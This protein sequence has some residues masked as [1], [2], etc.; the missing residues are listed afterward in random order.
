MKSQRFPWPSLKL[1]PAL[2]G[3]LLVLAGTLTGSVVVLLPLAAWTLAAAALALLLLLA[4]SYVRIGAAVLAV[5]GSRML[6]A[7]GNFPELL[8]F[9]HFP[10]V[11]LA[12][13]VAATEGAPLSSSRQALGYGLIALLA[14]CLL[15]W[16][17]NGGQPIRPLLDWLVFAEPFLLIY[18]LAAMP[19]DPRKMKALWGL[20]LALPFAQLPLAGYQALSQGISDPVQGLFLGM[21]AGAHVAGG[22]TLVGSLICLAKAAASAK[23]KA[24]PFWLLGG[25]F[26]FLVAVLADAKQVIIAFFPALVLML[27]GLVRLRW[28]RAIV[29]LP[30][31]AG[32]ILG[33]FSYYRPLQIVLDWTLISRGV[34]GKVQAFAV[35][36]SRFSSSPG[37]WIFGL[38][39]GNTVSRVALMSLERFVKPGSPVQL[40][41]LNP[42]LTTLELWNLT[43]SNWLFSASSVWSS[44]SSWLGLLG[45]LGLVGFG[46][47]IWM[48]L[49]IWRGLNSKAVWQTRIA[50]AVL[51][52]CGLLGFMFSWLEEPGFTIP[53]SLVVGLCLAIAQAREAGGSE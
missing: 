43:T 7:V 30:V 31:L 18:A 2:T 33:A 27:L 10:L 12:A 17:I 40:L 49:S 5:I 19:P 52:M 48:C 45:D 23:L 24:G 46:I 13:L 51:L 8:N 38:G 22:L 36:A 39:P 44:V 9:F 1:Q 53:A 14:T 26:L 16:I 15:S 3:A 35:V 6:V 37:A 42:A 29:A 47:Y 21:G 34:L 11:L 25:I 4:P 50:R 28:N 32:I 20:A 41:G